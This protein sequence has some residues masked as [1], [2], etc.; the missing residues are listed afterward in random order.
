MRGGRR[1]G[2]RDGRMGVVGR[3]IGGECM[4]RVRWE[5]RW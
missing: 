5:G 3:E 1:G 4:I 2:G